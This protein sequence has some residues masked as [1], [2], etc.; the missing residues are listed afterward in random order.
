MEELRTKRSKIKKHLGGLFS[1][2]VNFEN[3]NGRLKEAQVEGRRWKRACE[4]VVWEQRQRESVV[5]TQIH[6]FEEELAKSQAIAARQ[7]QLGIEVEQMLS[8]NWRRIYQEILNL[9]EQVNFQNQDHEVIVKEQGDRAEAWRI[10]HSNLAEFANK[11]VREIS[12]MFKR[13]DGVANFHNTPQE[14]IKFIR[15]CDVMLKEFKAYLK[16]AMEA[17][18]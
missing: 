9:R 4:L 3:L 12:R 11:L 5:M 13:V 10:E 15:L 1:A 8:L 7:R 16:R 6:G 14:V 17:P 2:G 18:L